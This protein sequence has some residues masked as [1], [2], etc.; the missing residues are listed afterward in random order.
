MDGISRRLGAGLL[1]AGLTIS[2][3]SSQA[4]QLLFPYVVNST[5]VTTILSVANLT[6][7]GHPG[8]GDQFLR[9]VYMYKSG[10]ASGAQD[11]LCARTPTI[12]LSSA[13]NDIQTFD[14]GG[15]FGAGTRGILFD[16]PSSN[17]NWNS[18]AQTWASLA[19]L[20]PVRAY[21]VID[22]N[23]NDD[24]DLWPAPYLYGEAFIYE[25][26]SGAAW[27]YQA[28]E[29]SGNGG[30]I[31]TD[32]TNNHR[33]PSAFIPNTRFSFM[34]TTEFNTRFFVTPIASE[35][36]DINAQGRI[37]IFPWVGEDLA[38]YD[39]D[40]NPVPGYVE[41]RAT[42]VAGLSIESMLT[43]SAASALQNGGW[44]YLLLSPTGGKFG[45]DLPGTVGAASASI[46]K[47]E[48]NKGATFNGETVGGVFNN[49]LML[50]GQAFSFEKF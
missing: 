7:P 46:I 29:D 43:N 1:A 44:A 45:G 17:N 32:F 12:Q 34:P 41:Q 49:A 27:G 5:T 47:L 42:C 25:F 33:L 2:G 22:N 4:S 36:T 10:A 18:G 26:G 14:V 28:L 13:P 9:H 15:Y 37:G 30:G 48:F 8:G 23:R 11:A 16:D 6:P 40:G 24:A 50:K 19:G 31:D 39:R 3:M 20:A 21:G 35:M 38:G